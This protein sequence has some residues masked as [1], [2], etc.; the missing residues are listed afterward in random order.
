MEK[1]GC[2][3]GF[4]DQQGRCDQASSVSPAVRGPSTGGDG[5][6]P[7]VHTHGDG[8]LLELEVVDM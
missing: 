7:S 5:E 3:Q 6:N 4:T 1:G 8:N 2:G